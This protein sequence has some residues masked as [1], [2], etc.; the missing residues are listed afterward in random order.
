M[1]KR[2]KVLSLLSVIAAM[3]FLVSGCVFAGGAE[4]STV[5]ENEGTTTSTE[6]EEPKEEAAETKSEP[7]EASGVNET[8]DV[9]YPIVDTGQIICYDNMNEISAPDEGEPF[10]GQ[11][12]QVDGNQ[13]SYIDNG[14]GTITDTVTGLMWQKDPGDKMTYGEAVAGADSFELAGY[15]DW[16]LPTIKELYSL[17][18]FSGTDPSGPQAS[19]A[20]PFI[21]TDYFIFEYGDESAG[22][23]MI[24]SQFISSTKYV[25]TTMN[26]D[27]TVFGVNFADGRIKGY[28][29][30][31]MKNQSEGKLFY[32]LYVRGNTGYGENDFSDN[33]DG[34]ITDN[35]TSLM[36]SQSDSGAGM[37]W[38]EALAWVQEKNDENY[39]GYSDWRLPNAKELE[40]IVDY[41]RSPDTTGSAAIDE[42]FDVSGIT[43]EAGEADYPYFWTSTTHIKSNG[44]GDG[45]V[46][47]CFGR[48]MGYMEEFGGWV[49]VHGAGAQRSDPKSGNASDYPQSFGPQG[50]ARRLT[51]Y[52]R[53]VRG[54]GLAGD[55]K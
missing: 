17:I 35:A 47:I 52:V 42:L 18:Q 4:I 40:S 1:N 9:F 55:Y 8:N 30:G 12:A 27:E 37:T 13:P 44:M 29:I 19:G 24:D 21:D 3:A 16:R 34:T 2:R 23:R 48:A 15:D 54:S 20:I 7:E 28:P 41:S 33:G 45:A 46:Y 31:P 32:V 49:D 43:N 11:D 51:N 39:L 10:Y 25:S 6:I 5:E 38:E 22:E 14:D 36:W 53:L 50:D 26:N